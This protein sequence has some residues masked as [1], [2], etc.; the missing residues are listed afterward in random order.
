MESA[1]QQGWVALL[2]QR[3]QAQGYGYQIVNASVSGET[4]SGGRA[5]AA[6]RVAAAPAGDRHS[7]AGRKRRP[8]RPA[9][10]GDARQSRQDG[11][12]GAGGRAHACC[13]SACA[14]RPTMGRVTAKSSPAYSPRSQ[15]NITCRSCR[16]CCRTSHWIRSSCSRTACTPM[17]AASR[18]C[19]KTSG[20]TC[21]RCSRRMRSR[22][23]LMD[24]IW[25]KSYPPEVPAEI[26]PTQLRSL[27]QLL[28]EA[29]AR[30][31]ERVAYVQM[32]TEL[33][34]RRLEELS[35]AFAAWLQH[36]GFS[37]GDRIAI[38]LPNT[39]QYPVAMFGA[40]RAGLIVVNTN[41]LYTAPELEHQL[42]DSGATAIVVLENFAHV[43]QKVLARTS[44]KRVLV[45]AVGDMLRFPKSLIVNF[46]VRHVRKQ[47]PAGT[48]RVRC[49][50][51]AALREGRKLPLT[52]VELGRGRPR[53]PAVHRRH[54]R[55]GEG[56]DAHA[57]QRESPT[58]CR[59][60]AW[61]GQSF[62]D[63]RRSADHRHPAVPHLR[64]DGELHAVRAS[65]LEER[66]HHQPARSASADCRHET[67]STQF[68]QRRQH[69]VQRAAAR[70][71][72]QPGRLQHAQS[73][74]RRR[75]GGTGSRRRALERGDRQ[76]AHAGLGSHRNLAR[77]LHQSQQ[78]A[79]QRLDR[80][81]DPV[82]RDRHQGRRRQRPA[83]RPDRRNLRARTAGDARLLEP[84]RRDRKSHAARRL[85]AHRRRRPHGCERLR[86]SSR[87][88]RR[89]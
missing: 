17:P 81:A 16:S 36:A 2:T 42:T 61:I 52:P 8:A 87:I 53:L 59:R 64:A 18:W 15:V 79:V 35:G 29:C 56:R 68:H 72:V 82:H 5:A 67:L 88:A 4:T 71:R 1:P 63:L 26:D 3:L 27:K 23:I 86:L 51:N 45:T 60:E 30:Y 80:P 39:L 33:T 50:F 65:R 43:L 37:K 66:A 85:A 21:C 40:L 12:A 10:S 74:S 58:S 75:H 6:A 34:F 55:R 89:T 44:V 25:L 83:D 24:R 47:V 31:P 7:G 19:W 9:G 77:R 13:S 62:R 22:G 69:P 28:E 73:D 32:G 46:V 49:R 11:A 84:P 20:R 57:R 14:C 70:A 38:M 54:H 48:S 78:R 41:P 76:R